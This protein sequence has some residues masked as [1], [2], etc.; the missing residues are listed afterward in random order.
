MAKVVTDDSHYKAIAEAIRSG[1]NLDLSEPFG[2]DKM[3]PKDMPE[4][5]SF[6]LEIAHEDGLNTGIE[7]GAEVWF[8]E[9]YSAGYSEGHADGVE[10]GIT[11]GKQ[12]E[13]DRF[14]DAYQQNGNRTDYRYGFAG[15]A[16]TE[17]TFK[18]KHSFIVKDVAQSMFQYFGFVGDLA[19]HLDDLGVT[20]DLSRSYNTHSLFN[21]AQQITRVPEINISSAGAANSALFAYCTKLVTI[22]KFVVTA[23]NAWSS[24]FQGCDNLE[25]LTIEGTIGVSGLNIQWS[26]KLTHDSLMSIINALEDKSGVGGTWTVTLGTTN[27][28]KL[29][30][31]ELKIAENKGWTVN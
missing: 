24:T 9:G 1:I 22:D 15:P 4:R 18:P 29:T 17:E 12:A 14:W 28:A 3:Q 6:V 25:N 21:S 26:T 10:D 2:T 16:W 20:L 13:Y 5:I 30:T 11:E 27:L 8:D 19:Q 31:D 7:H 23:T